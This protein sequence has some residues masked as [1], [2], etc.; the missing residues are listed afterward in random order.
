MN[1][2]KNNYQNEYSRSRGLKE[3]ELLC[4]SK[5]NFFNLHNNS[6]SL[7]PGA[8]ITHNATLPLSDITGGNLSDYMQLPLEPQKALYCFFFIYA[9]VLTKTCKCTLMY[10]IGGVTL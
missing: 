10:I 3:E 4:D 5:G 7:N 8:Y 6:A 9:A 2:L 1:S